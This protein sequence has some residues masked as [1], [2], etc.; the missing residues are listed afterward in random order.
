MQMFMQR[1]GL[2]TFA[3]K[4]LLEKQLAE[5]PTKSALRVTHQNIRW[6]YAN[7]HDHSVAL[8]SGLVDVGLGPGSC[9][10]AVLGNNAENVSVMLG[11][12]NAGMKVASASSSDKLTKESLGR[13]LSN[14]KCSVLFISPDKISVVYELLPELKGMRL[15]QSVELKLEAYPELKYICHTGISAV[16]GMHRFR[17]ILLYNA[18]PNR[19]ENIAEKDDAPFFVQIDGASGSTKSEMTQKEAIAAAEKK[20]GEL[21]LDGKSR[22]LFKVKKD[23]PTNLVLGTLACASSNAQ[24][25]VPS[26]V[27]DE[28][29]CEKAILEDSCN[30]TLK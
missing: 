8:A 17:D 2:A 12:A 19:L 14:N 20:A 24:L 13:I 10:G 29:A 25:V 30:A 16:A 28:S 7:L 21:K 26:D 15:D 23:Y 27:F 4:S 22:V 5:F 1:R 3:V 18:I 6:T 9:V 11:A